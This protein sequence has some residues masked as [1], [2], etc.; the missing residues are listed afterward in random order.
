MRR[1]DHEAAGAAHVAQQILD[2]DGIQRVEPGEGLVEDEDVGI[3]QERA[4]DLH[5]LLHPFRELVDAAPGGLRQADPIEP[6]LGAGPGRPAGEP[7]EHAE[8]DQDLPHLLLAV[9]AAL[10][11]QVADPV[12]VGAL[13]RPAVQKD[14]SCVRDEDAHEESEKGGLPRPVGPEEPED[15]APAHLERDVVHG[16]S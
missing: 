8:V 11:G 6:L 7:L 15:F 4:R 12:A 16:Q 10:L 2:E 5:L 9:E 3:V 13:E 14:F 1:E